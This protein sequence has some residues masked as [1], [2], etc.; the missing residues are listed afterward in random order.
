MAL[1]GEIFGLIGP[2]GAG[3]T[4]LIKMLT[5]LLPPSSGKRAGRRLRHRQEAAEVR[6]DI[7]YVPQLLSADG[8]H[9]PATK[10]CSCPPVSTR[11]PGAS[12][13]RIARRSQL[14]DLTDAADRWCIPI[15]A[16]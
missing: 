10:T 15:R 6:G 12:A 5:T 8:D 7:G 11:S 4:T 13:R 14:M 3:K 16:A 9:S 2:N 1:H